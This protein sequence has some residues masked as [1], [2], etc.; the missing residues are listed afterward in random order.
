[1]N[2]LADSLLQRGMLLFDSCDY[3]GSLSVLQRAHQ[4]FVK[5]RDSIYISLT[6]RSI[7]ECYWRMGEFDNAINSI[8]EALAIDSIM[9]NEDHLSS[10]YHNLAAFYKNKIPFSD[11]YKR[12]AKENIDRAI[13]IERKLNRHDKLALRYGIASEIYLKIGLKE[14]ALQ[15]ARL[16]YDEDRQAGDTA[17]MYIHRSQIG[18]I[19]RAMQRYEEAESIFSE[20]ISHYES[21]QSFTSSLVINYIELGYLYK[22]Q[23]RDDE[24]I[25]L[26]SKGKQLARRLHMQQKVEVCALML[27]RIYEKKK[28]YDKAG[29]E[30]KEAYIARD[31][32][33]KEENKTFTSMYN[34]K[35][36]NDLKE[37]VIL[38]Q[39]SKLNTNHTLL[40]ITIVLILLVAVTLSLLYHK[41]RWPFKVR[42]K[43]VKEIV[44]VEKNISSEPVPEEEDVF[45]Q[46]L[47]KVIMDN[48]ELSE[49][50][51]AYLADKFSMSQRH[52]NRK[53]KETTGKD[54]T[55]YIREMR[56]KEAKR[57]LETT[58]ESISEIYMR[59]GFDNPSYFSRVFKQ[60]VGISPSEYKK[61]R[62]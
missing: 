37:H 20:A 29:N 10:D 60:I 18:Q 39:Q 9:G 62:P 51:S 34:M 43:K 23:G 3:V 15:F 42:E 59:C 41:Q 14:E 5:K 58:R 49:L 1:M 12:L 4:I 2:T 28:L 24:A 40:L 61:L 45:K 52:L 44:L 32:V 19:L 25:Q 48:L 47:D 21:N 46:Q 55:N 36:D 30:M 35:I 16:G 26:F 56:I 27:Q 8:L 7:S 22:E 17:N 38:E 57:L 31:S 53:V 6:D 11:Q 54:T 13:K 33:I 50:S